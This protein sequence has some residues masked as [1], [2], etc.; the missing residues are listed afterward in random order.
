VGIQSNENPIQIG[1]VIAVDLATGHKISTFNFQ[2]V[3]TPTPLPGSVPVRGGGVWNGPATDGTG[4]YFTTGNTNIDGGNP[5]QKTE[6]DPN[7]GLS[8]IRVDKDTGNIIWAFQPVP[9]ALDADPDWAAGATIMS[10]SCGEMI[11]SVQKDGYSYAVNPGNGVPGL[12]SVAWQFPPDGV[13]FQS[14]RISISTPAGNV[15]SADKNGF[16]HGDNDYRR[17]GA[18]WN[19][20]FIVRTGGES[21]KFNSPSASGYLKLHALNACATT[22]RTR[23]RWIADF[24]DVADADV[25]K[26]GWPLTAPTVTGG[27]VFV[28]TNKGLLVV[29]ADPSVSA[30]LG[31]TCS[32]NDPTANAQAC[33]SSPNFSMVPQPSRVAV[34][35]VTGNSASLVAIRNEPVLAKG[36]V[37]VTS[38]GLTPTGQPIG[39]LYM[40]DTVPPDIPRCSQGG[41][42]STPRQCCV[43]NG[44]S[45][46]GG[47]CR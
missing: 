7:H 23:V 37:F 21:V 14:N 6:P 22:E 17:P 46:E 27:L 32:S 34:V 3:G 15:Y 44:G 13:P 35:D 8:L 33:L 19:D 43:C 11:A 12:P 40:L 20:V 4:I 42:C 5:P 16:V 31:Y 26:A 38:N 36:R 45:W 9:F 24:S 39:S 18:A 29:L 2:A 28:G 25:K 41:S 30:P 10:T 1:R 47:H